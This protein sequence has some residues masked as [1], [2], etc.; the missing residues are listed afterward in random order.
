[1]PRG[2]CW[3]RRDWLPLDHAYAR[4]EEWGRGPLPEI[5]RVLVTVRSV[6]FGIMLAAGLAFLLWLTQ[7]AENLSVFGIQSTRVRPG[8]AVGSLLALIPA[9]IAVHAILDDQGAQKVIPAIVIACLAAP[10]IVIR[11]LWVAS[12]LPAADSGSEDGPAASP[13]TGI[14]V[15]WAAFTVYWMSARLALTMF[16]A[17]DADAY[18]AE[19]TA[20]R[21]MA[22]GSFE[23]IAGVAWA[24]AA[25]FAV[26]IMFRINAMQDAQASRLRQSTARPERGETGPVQRTTGQWQCESCE[27]M[28]PTALRFCQHCA[29][30]RG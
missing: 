10:L 6:W 5:E 26:R 1:M 12:S 20:L 22:S 28:N 7:A 25:V 23:F 29:S 17:S 24:T 16:E 3:R 15:W 18:T 8:L 19:E 4:V 9:L 11:R 21:V 13:W 27:V 14:L 30:E 2:C